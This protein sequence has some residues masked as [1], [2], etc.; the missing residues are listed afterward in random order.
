MA[1]AAEPAE[2]GQ[3]APMAAPPQR[4]VYVIFEGGGAKG[5]AHAGAAKALE[6]AALAPAGVA[7]SSAGAIIAALLAVGFEP[8]EIFAIAQDGSIST[9]ITRPDARGRRQTPVGLLGRRDWWCFQLIWHCWLPALVLTLLAALRFGDWRL[10][11]PGLCWPVIAGLMT[12]S[13]APVRLLWSGG[14]F[15]TGRMRAFI[16]RVIAEKI[17]HAG[18]RPV[19]FGDIAATGLPLKI[20][21][22][23]IRSGQLLVID[24]RHADVAIADAV[25]ASLSI[26]FIFPPARIAGLEP[27][28]ALPRYLDGGLISNLPSWAF[29][30]EKTRLERR[31]RGRVVRPIPIVAFSLFDPPRHDRADWLAPVRRWLAARNP[32]Q[33]V[34]RVLRLGVF[35][36][37]SVVRRLVPDV[38]P[39]EIPVELG[40]LAF[41]CSGADARRA[42]DAGRTTA[43]RR[44]ILQLRNAPDLARQELGRIIAEAETRLTALAPAARLRA[45]LVAPVG[46][47]GV[48]ELRVRV[49]ANM[50]DDADDRLRLDTDGPIGAAYAYQSGDFHHAAI[51]A[52]S[53]LDLMTKYENAMVRRSLTDII[54]VPI[55]PSLDYWL[56]P[57][58]RT[59]MSEEER[60]KVSGVLCLDADVSLCS[61]ARDTAFRNWLIAQSVGLAPI[62][63]GLEGDVG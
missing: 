43:S 7:G 62:L 23:D 46:V 13:P 31:L 30:T 58:L 42:Y 56:D 34:I 49:A 28:P 18:P 25:V 3:T 33:F 52:G 5:I 10:V 35:G 59:Q 2:S 50:D 21:V 16:D 51:A 40:V 11:L 55:F 24:S 57:E 27:G 20:T 61:A 12:L 14:F 60:L 48:T 15:H 32:A 26:P 17:G 45:A 1:D 19:R 44:L 54:A 6:L 4:L 47:D 29:L 8:D 38:F 41:D 63:R 53:Q 37:Q 9:I 22:S 36:S 39:V